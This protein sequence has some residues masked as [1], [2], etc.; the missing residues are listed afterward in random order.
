MHIGM[1]M[2][3]TIYILILRAKSIWCFAIP[4]T[5]DTVVSRDNEFY[6]NNEPVTYVY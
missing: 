4:V 3:L 6:I 5:V 2:Y 1:S